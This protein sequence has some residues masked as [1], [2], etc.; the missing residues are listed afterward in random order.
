MTI[1]HDA[2]GLLNSFRGLP[3]PNPS[4][5]PADKECKFHEYKQLAVSLE[6]VKT[7]FALY[8]LLDDQVR[9]LKGWFCDTLP[10]A[11]ISKLSILRLDG[12]LYESTMDS[13]VNLYPKLSIGGYLII[14]DYNIPC[15]RKAVNDFRN[16]FN[17]NEAIQYIDQSAIFWK[18]LK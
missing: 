6:E 8:N 12:D 2:Y 9:F 11:P 5:Y 16:T 3:A 15:C 17:I 4:L 10:H 13:L 18:R 14:D 7:N 1:P